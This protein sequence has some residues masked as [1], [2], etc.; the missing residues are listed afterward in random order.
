MIHTDDRA[1]LAH[2]LLQQSLAKKESFEAFAKTQGYDLRTCAELRE[3]HSVGGTRLATY[4]DDHT[5]HAWRGWANHPVVD[6]VLLAAL[7]DLVSSLPSKRDW[8]DPETER[9]L[10]SYTNSAAGA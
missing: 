5:E 2:A 1:A 9:I 3:L 8:L 10:K 6:R 4:W 7:R